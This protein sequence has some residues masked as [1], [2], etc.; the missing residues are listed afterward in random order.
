MDCW[1]FVF[2]VGPSPQQNQ[3]LSFVG[4]NHPQPIAIGI[5][6]VGEGGIAYF[7]VSGGGFRDWPCGSSTR[8]PIILVIEQRSVRIAVERPVD[9]AG[10]HSIKT[11]CLYEMSR[12]RLGVLLILSREVSV[13]RY[14]GQKSSLIGEAAL[15]WPAHAA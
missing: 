10:S 5:T 8:N 11:C 3:W 14:P 2:K 12:V 6:T 4:S 15:S 13:D 7:F 9:S 1:V